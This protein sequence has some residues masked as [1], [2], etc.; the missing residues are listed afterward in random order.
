ML[1]RHIYLEQRFRETPTAHVNVGR[2]LPA[3]TSTNE[4]WSCET[5]A[6]DELKRYLTGTGPIPEQRALEALQ[7][8]QLHPYYY[9]RSAHLLPGDRTLLKHFRKWLRHQH[10]A[11]NSSSIKNCGQP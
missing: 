7:D 1:S 9:S 6:V 5:R 8:D 10:T 4:D 2:P 3:R 11:D